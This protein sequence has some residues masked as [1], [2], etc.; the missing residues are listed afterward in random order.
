VMSPRN[1]LTFWSSTQIFLPRRC[2][3]WRGWSSRSLTGDD[4]GVAIA[5]ARTIRTHRVDG[6]DQLASSC[7]PA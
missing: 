3:W 2:T 6:R 5:S 1:E 7:I 4:Q